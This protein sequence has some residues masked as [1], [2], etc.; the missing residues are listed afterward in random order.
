MHIPII[1]TKAINPIT[2]GM[3]HIKSGNKALEIWQLITAFLQVY[4]ALWLYLLE[5]HI[6]QTNISQN[7]LALAFIFIPK[8]IVQTFS[9]K[10]I[11]NLWPIC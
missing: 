11:P 6:L 10:I 5:N 3:H 7:L 9:F 2:V 1:T 8:Q 4:R